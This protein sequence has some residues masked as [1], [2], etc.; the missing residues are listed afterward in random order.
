MGLG[1]FGLEFTYSPT[2]S[3]RDFPLTSFL[4]E[5]VASSD[6]VG[7]TGALFFWIGILLATF[8]MRS[9]TS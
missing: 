3:E 1:G 4:R 9:N 6:F 5:A 8:L 2:E 7:V